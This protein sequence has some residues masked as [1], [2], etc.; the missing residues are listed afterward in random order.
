MN[1]SHLCQG[2]FEV[3]A[4]LLRIDCASA[5]LTELEISRNLDAIVGFDEGRVSDQKDFNHC[6]L[7]CGLL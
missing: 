1:K 4:F 6:L 5:L 2:T 3:E 7:G